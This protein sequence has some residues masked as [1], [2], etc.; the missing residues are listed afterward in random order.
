[1][2]SAQERNFVAAGREINALIQHELMKAV[3]LRDGTRIDEIRAL[4]PPL[5]HRPEKA[6]DMGAVQPW[7]SFERFGPEVGAMIQ[8]CIKSGRKH[9]QSRQ[10]R[11]HGH[12]IS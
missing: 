1:M 6:S 5:E 8:I 11:G 10:A 3:E 4:D 9:L 7:N 2:G 12:W